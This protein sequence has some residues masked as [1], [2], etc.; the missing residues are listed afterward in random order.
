MADNIHKIVVEADTSKAIDELKKLSDAMKN[1]SLSTGKVVSSNSSLSSSF[2]SLSGIASKLGIA[3]TGAGIVSGLYSL[4]K[5]ALTSSSQVEQI[6]VSFEV[7]TGSAETAKN[8]LMQ[9]KDQ[10][11]KS[12]MQFQD[13]TKGAQT[14]LGYGLTAQQVI[15]ITKM[16][17][18]ISGGNADKFG[19]LSLAFGQVVAAGRLMGQETRQMINAGFNPLQAISD[20]T[21]KSM[22]QLTQDMK[23]GKISVNDV[24]QAFVYATSEGGRFFGMAEKQALTVGGALNKLSESIFFATAD[25]GAYGAKV[26]N[27]GGIINSLTTYMNNLTQVVK[28]LLD[29]FK[30]G[31]FI[32]D[33]LGKIFTRLSG[34]IIVAVK[35]FDY[36]L[37]AINKIGEGLRFLGDLLTRLY[38][39]LAKVF[40]SIFDWT[41]KLIDNV[42]KNA[43][44]S[45][46]INNIS[47]SLVSMRK[48]LEELEA[49]RELQLKINPLMVDETTKKINKLKQDI[50]ILESTTAKKT[51]VS[52]FSTTP[53]GV[54]GDEM[55]KAEKAKYDKLVEQARL[56]YTEINKQMRTGFETRLEIFDRYAKEELDKFRK[57]NID[58]IKVEKAQWAMRQTIAKVESQKLDNLVNRNSGSGSLQNLREAMNKLFTRDAE[59]S[60][61]ISSPLERTMSMFSGRTMDTY[62]KNL[63]SNANKFNLAIDEFVVNDNQSKIATYA[64]SLTSSLQDF[65]VNLYS[66]FANLAGAALSG[67]TSFEDAISRVGSLFLNLVGDLLIQMGTSAIKLGTSA[68]AIKA[69]LSSLGV[70]GGGFAAIAIGTAAVAAGSLLKSM[71]TKTENAIDAKNQ[72]LADKANSKINTKLPSAGARTSGTSY[73][74]GGSSYS[75]QSIK[76]SIDLTGAI[77]A[78]P[79]GYNINKSMETVL[80]VTGR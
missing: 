65:S 11:L 37:I 47:E 66:G 78:S 25:L 39:H 6:G 17:G 48:E 2:S 73:Q 46:S 41:G 64:Q 54:G 80:R 76:L 14:L 50:A 8:M 63:A 58:T 45:K 29:N 52:G 31:T 56:G 75:T 43:A 23:N 49:K 24:A 38:P 4:G 77:T 72:A 35:A 16:L 42:G 7:F 34:L 1:Y 51:A 13:I 59:R 70:P 62:I 79:T 5:A 68:E 53:T 61:R 71:A 55:N 67:I 74:Y 28:P 44:T 22:A 57:Y 33:L 32:G 15:P 20:K 40:T 10:A 26:L 27:L 21:G 19:R 69:V 12:P 18:D 9:L 3:L 60:Q 30:Q 36:L